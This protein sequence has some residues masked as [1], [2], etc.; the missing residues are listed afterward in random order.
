M[1]KK[2]VLIST[3]MAVFFTF[4][5]TLRAGV[6]SFGDNIS[7]GLQGG[8]NVA[9]FIGDDDFTEEYLEESDEEEISIDFDKNAVSGLALG[10][11]VNIPF[12]DS[13]SL[14]PELY[15][16]QKGV[17]YNWESNT[18]LDI[19]V[20]IDLDVNYL[21]MPVLV[22]YD[23]DTLF[24]I[25]PNVY[26]GPQVGVKVASDSSYDINIPEDIGNDEVEEPEEVLDKIEYRSAEL[27]IVAGGGVEMDSFKFDLRYT[28][29]LTSIDDTD[30]L[31]VRNSVFS[32]MA[33]YRF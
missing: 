18:F 8:G 2:K 11:F 13:F 29:G 9:S 19:E 14:Q 15:Y 28:M 7:F 26:A 6:I 25:V 1:K 27:G 3:A 32:I 17:N 10:G 24:D 16:S 31:D 20:D 4:C 30:D 21:D 22:R 5:S 12:S 33:G 23:I